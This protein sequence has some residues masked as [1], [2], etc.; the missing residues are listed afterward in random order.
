M[1]TFCISASNQAERMYK[2]SQLASA[3]DLISYYFR[4]LIAITYSLP[5]SVAD[6]NLQEKVGASGMFINRRL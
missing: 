4:A 3:P 5:L 6:D 1:Y 2:L